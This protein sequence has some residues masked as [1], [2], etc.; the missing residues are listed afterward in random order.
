MS[1][2]AVQPAAGG[3]APEPAAGSSSSATLPDHVAKSVTCGDL[4][5]LTSWLECEQRP[6]CGQPRC[7]GPH[8]ADAGSGGGPARARAGA[9]TTRSEPRRQAAPGDHR[10]H[11]RLLRRRHWPCEGAPRRQGKAQPCGQSRA[12]GAALRAPQGSHRG[13]PPPAAALPL[14]LRP[15]LRV[16]R[17]VRLVRLRRL[18]DCGLTIDAWWPARFALG[19]YARSAEL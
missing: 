12:V 18:Y 3:E 10:P 1:G 14:R 6:S 17:L 8:A 2:A 19:A 9:D 16:L 11:V 7:Q 4:A 5:A 15:C 13:V